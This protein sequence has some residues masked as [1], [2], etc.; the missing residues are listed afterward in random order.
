MTKKKGKKNHT[1]KPQQ[2]NFSW[3]VCSSFDFIDLPFFLLANILPPTSD[4]NTKMKR[5]II[6]F[7]LLFFRSSEEINFKKYVY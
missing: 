1:R 7:F 3:Y 5:R 4:K 2:E 6:I